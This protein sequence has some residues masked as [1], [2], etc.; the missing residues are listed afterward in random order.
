MKNDIRINGWILFVCIIFVTIVSS[1]ELVEKKAGQERS[2]EGS[3]KADSTDIQRGSLSH[4]QNPAEKDPSISIN[5]YDSL[6]MQ[7]GNEKEVD[8]L[9]LKAIM[10]KESHGKTNHISTSGAVGLMQLMPRDGSYFDQNYHNYQAARKQAI[11]GDGLRYFQ[12]KSELFWANAYKKVLDSIQESL[13]RQE[14]YQK[15]LRFDPLW[16]IR[17]AGRQFSSDYHFFKSRHNGSYRA[18]LLAFAAY[19]A[20]RYAVM[21]DRDNPRMDHIPINRQTELYVANVERIYQEL[22]KSNGKLEG[23]NTWI[24]KL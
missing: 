6:F 8:W 19:N 10:I 22:K 2:N 12:G 1:N 11:Q 7:V 9:W 5:L 24:L 20:G 16:N 23:Q 21:K 17:E 15:D 14:L 3:E 13:S 4:R 18:R